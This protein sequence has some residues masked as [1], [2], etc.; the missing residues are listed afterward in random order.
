M[1]SSNSGINSNGTLDYGPPCPPKQGGNLANNQVPP[2]ADRISTTHRDV[3]T[4][5]TQIAELRFVPISLE[6]T[7]SMTAL[8]TRVHQLRL[9]IEQQ[10][11]ELET[12]QMREKEPKTHYTL[13]LKIDDL[14]GDFSNLENKIR[15]I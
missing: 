7:H 11:L 5:L 1:Q 8:K 9:T 15:F 13:L 10:E 2:L 12:S 3:D 14:E 4:C 6:Q